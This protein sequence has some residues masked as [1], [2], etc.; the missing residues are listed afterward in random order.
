MTPSGIKPATFRLVTQCLNQLRHHVPVVNSDVSVGKTYNHGR[1]VIFVSCRYL[2][3]LNYVFYTI[4]Y[5]KQIIYFNA[6]YLFLKIVSSYLI[7]PCLT[8]DIQH[9]Y[10]FANKYPFAKSIFRTVAQ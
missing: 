10:V 5:S 2:A 9:I 8:R 1:Q 3:I 6:F 4:G 7:H